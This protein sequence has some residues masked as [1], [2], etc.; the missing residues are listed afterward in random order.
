MR[1]AF[2]HDHTRA[3][4]VT[5]LCAVLGVSRSGYY[6]WLK[7]KPSKRESSDQKLLPAIIQVHQESRCSYGS[8][9]VAQTVSGLGNVRRLGER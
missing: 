1:Y 2:I 6:A 3:H 8:P 7:R 9:R 5:R 4:R